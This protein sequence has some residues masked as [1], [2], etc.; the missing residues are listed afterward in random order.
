MQYLFYRDGKPEKVQPERWQ[1]VA[2]YNDGTEL[3]QFESPEKE[4][5]H[6][7]FH[8]IREIDEKKLHVFRM[9]NPETGKF[10]DI[11]IEP[12]MHFYHQYRRITLRKGAP[13]EQKI[14][15]YMFGYTKKYWGKTH[16]L[17][18]FILPDDSLIT[19][20]HPE[21]LRVE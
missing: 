3:R 7:L 6:G 17:I 5:V 4:G 11:L 21:L 13:N 10:H 20:E 1:W 14:T 8:Q 19:T 16:K 9:I 2:M 15:W 12:G 18:N